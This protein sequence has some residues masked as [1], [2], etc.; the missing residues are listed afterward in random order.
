MHSMFRALGVC[1]AV[2]SLQG[3]V[4]PA[5]ATTITGTLVVPSGAAAT[6]RVPGSVATGTPVASQAEAT[7]TAWVE[8]ADLNVPTIQP[9][10]GSVTFST[11]G[12]YVVSLDDG[13]LTAI[14]SGD[15]GVANLIVGMHN[16]GD[17]S[18]AN[19][20]AFGAIARSSTSGITLDA[21]GLA[22]LRS[23][24]LPS[25]S[26]AAPRSAPQTVAPFIGVP[27]PCTVTLV[28]RS[29]A[30]ATH[31][32]YWDTWGDMSLHGGYTDGNNTSFSVGWSGNGTSG[33]TASG[34]FATSSGTVVSGSLPSISGGLREWL[35][36]HWDVGKYHHVGG[37]Y[38][39]AYSTH[40]IQFDGGFVLNG[41]SPTPPVGNWGHCDNA[42][43]SPF[44]QSGGPGQYVK[45]ASSY[46][47]TIGGALGL[48]GFSFT[49]STS[50]DSSH[51]LQW[52]FPTSGK[53]YYL[54][55]GVNQPISKAPVI[56]AGPVK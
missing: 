37:C 42:G 51:Y 5:D 47:Q 35:D 7:I 44:I 22:R 20:A 19:D 49:A 40:Q 28:S 56:Y 41:V 43:L 8:P 13:R 27:P 11:D 14:A 36:S 46:T 16:L 34:T 6:G 32:Y 10:V 54:C 50:S 15:G 21:D 39:P 23:L 17:P 33:W 31:T 4:P 1:L 48:F 18:H 3:L 52:N 25:A 45:I 53:V 55:G 38:T 12:S 9:I 24:T 29:N 30:K 2:A 26:S